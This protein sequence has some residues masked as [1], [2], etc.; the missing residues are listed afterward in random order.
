MIRIIIK[1]RLVD[2]SLGRGEESYVSI[3]VALP[4]VEELLRKRA[5]GKS[6]FETNTFVG[7]E[8]LGERG[9][10]ESVC[11]ICRK[12]PEDRGI[13]DESMELLQ[14]PKET[15]D[16]EPNP[17]GLTITFSGISPLHLIGEC[18][19]CDYD[20]IKAHIFK[21][22]KVFDADSQDYPT[23]RQYKEIMDWARTKGYEKLWSNGE[24]QD[25]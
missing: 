5:I 24:L 23:G 4:E 21:E 17:G 13:Y 22:L 1:K 7:L 8:V 11:P 15:V 18:S 3:D 6:G 19:W 9:K 10:I 25:E 20:K 2:L 14:L 16:V 12:N